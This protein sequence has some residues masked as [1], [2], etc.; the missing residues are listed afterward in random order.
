MHLVLPSDATGWK[1]SA[2]ELAGWQRTRHKRNRKTKKRRKHR[3]PGYHHNNKTQ[4]SH[5]HY[6]TYVPGIHV[7]SIRNMTN[8]HAEPATLP[9]FLRL[10]PLYCSKK[11]IKKVT[12]FSHGKNESQATGKVSAY[13]TSHRDTERDHK[14]T[15]GIWDGIS[16]WKY[17]YFY[18]D[19]YLDSAFCP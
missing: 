19:R 10:F 16:Y 7:F 15:R 5:R 13:K 14:I 3:P 1:E 18:N 12:F 2:A 17:T 6:H 9:S 4:R 11:H 8:E